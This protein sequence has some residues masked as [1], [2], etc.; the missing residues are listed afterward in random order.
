MLAQ[1][2]HDPNAA[3][4]LITTDKNLPGKVGQEIAGLLQN[5]PRKEIIVQALNNS[6][7]TI[8]ADMEEAIAASDVLHLSTSQSRWQIPYQLSPE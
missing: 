2:E 8:V 1:A 3:C 6:G 5:A 4:I 7:Y